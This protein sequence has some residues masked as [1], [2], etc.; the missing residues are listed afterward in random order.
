MSNISLI[1]CNAVLASVGVAL[2][3]T[4]SPY[5]AVCVVGLVVVNNVSVATEFK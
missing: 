1:I 3:L 2:V 4:D 5:L